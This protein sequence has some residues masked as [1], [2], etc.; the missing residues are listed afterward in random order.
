MSIKYSRQWY[1]IKYICFGV[2]V[3]FFLYYLPLHFVKLLMMFRHGSQT[4]A[5][6]FKNITSK[7][8]R[9]KENGEVDKGTQKDNNNNRHKNGILI[10]FL[11]RIKKPATASN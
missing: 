7:I 2:V 3:G 1:C 6:K 11:Y 8:H 4:L 9:P 5:W 10:Q